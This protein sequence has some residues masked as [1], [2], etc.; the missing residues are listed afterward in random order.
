MVWQYAQTSW[1]WCEY[2]LNNLIELENSL[3][4]WTLLNVPANIDNITMLRYKGESS[5]ESHYFTQLLKNYPTNLLS[6]GN[7]LIY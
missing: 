5:Q 7:I 6:E 4:T 1:K 3:S 2:P